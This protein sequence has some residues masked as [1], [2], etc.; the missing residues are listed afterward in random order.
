MVKGD[1][2][3]FTRRAYAFSVHI[4][5]IYLGLDDIF[6]TMTVK[7]VKQGAWIEIKKKIWSESILG[8]PICIYCK[9][10]NAV[11][12]AHGIIHKRYSVPRL[13]KYI[14]VEEDACPCC[15]DCQEFSETRDGRIVAWIW[16]CKKFGGTHMKSWL[17]D[18]PFNYK[19]KF[20]E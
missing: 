15:D 20:D 5:R 6:K 19:E 3:E 7:Y 2:D 12:L 8:V 10:R 16:L 9:I 14:N 17:A 4:Y 1:K 13:H 11:Q 18:L